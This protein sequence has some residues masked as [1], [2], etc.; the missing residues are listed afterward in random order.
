VD[1]AIHCFLVG[2]TFG[3]RYAQTKKPA[4]TTTESHTRIVILLISI[5]KGVPRNRVTMG[6]KMKSCRP[7]GWNPPSS[8]AARIEVARFA[9]TAIPS[10]P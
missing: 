4:I 1:S 5:S 8:L 6:A 10:T 3:L 2:T 7:G 9:F